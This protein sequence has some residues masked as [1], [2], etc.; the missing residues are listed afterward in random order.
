MLFLVY[1]VILP[2]CPWTHGSG[3]AAC[4]G[5]GREVNMN[6]RTIAHVG[7]AYKRE[8]RR[9]A[10][11]DLI[12]NANAISGST[13]VARRADISRAARTPPSAPP[14]KLWSKSYFGGRGQIGGQKSQQ[15]RVCDFA[16]ALTDRFPA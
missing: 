8:P 12:C 16:T 11:P 15:L 13:L 9:H 3:D 4:A 5:L 6:K 1:S 10:V 7:E 2:L 14:I